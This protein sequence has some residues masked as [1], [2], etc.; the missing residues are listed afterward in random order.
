MKS[1]RRSICIVKII[2]HQAAQ[3]QWGHITIKLATSLELERSIKKPGYK[4][5]LNWMVFVVMLIIPNSKSI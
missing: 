5:G 2:E 4:I 3:R 1:V